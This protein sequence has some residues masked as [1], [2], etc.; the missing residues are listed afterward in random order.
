MLGIKKAI[1][2]LMVWK[3]YREGEYIDTNNVATKCIDHKEFI[4][5]KTELKDALQEFAEF[6]ELDKNDIYTATPICGDKNHLIAFG[7]DL[8]GD[9]INEHCSDCNDYHA[10]WF[11]VEVS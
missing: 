6:F 11:C 10:Q 1:G 4:S 7:W 2:E 9:P 3:F 5:E 8:P